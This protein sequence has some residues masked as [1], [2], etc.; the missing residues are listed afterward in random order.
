MA[1]TGPLPRHYKRKGT[2]A[3][4]DD[5][6]DDRRRR[7]LTPRKLF[8][9][10]FFSLLALS[11]LDTPIAS[12]YQRVSHHLCHKTQSVEERAR[13]IL[14][15][16]P[17]IDGHVDFPIALRFA[18]GNHI[19][20]ETFREKFENGN[21]LGHV[22]LPRLREGQS[23]GAFWSVFAP[24]PSNIT[25][26]SDEN[27]AAALQFT[28]DQIDV[29]NRL[30]AL[31]SKDFSQ[32]SDSHGA[33]QDFKQGKLIS[34][35]GVEGLHQIANSVSNLRTFYALG[36]RYA[37][38]THNCNNKFADAASFG[39][40]KADPVWGGVSPLGQQIVH[41]MNR[42]GMIVDLSHVSDD[43]MVHTLGG[44]DDWSGSQAPVIFS[45][46]SAWSVCP[47]PRNVKDHV[48]QLVKARNSLVMV[49]IAPEFISCIDNGNESGIP[50]F[51]PEHSNLDQVVKHI[52]HIGELIGYDHVG[53]GSDFDGI[54]S[55]PEGFEDV[56]KYPDLIAELLRRGVSDADAAKIVGG[57][58]LRV[59]GEVEAVAAKM[60]Q[61][62]AYIMEDERPAMFSGLAFTD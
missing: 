46:S 33:L 29:T 54:S 21:L 24:C 43:T 4:F 53:I 7:R 38:L 17:L 49:N 39:D 41:E 26:F 47:H 5:D 9:V 25:D 2:D 52:M 48:L 1:P 18:Y 20:N 36:V 62:G 14:K 23:G 3:V 50:D 60:Q 58:A 15:H 12:S 27:Y 28:L 35:L 32:S 8:L 13:S 40:R 57:N 55:V 51:D 22:D 30:R 19:Y 42:L 37:T 6:L 10:V 11:L 44:R 59:W 56:S 34:P 31:Y 45:H 16:T 61:A